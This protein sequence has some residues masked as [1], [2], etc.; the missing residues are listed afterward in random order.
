MDLIRLTDEDIIEE[1]HKSIYELIADAIHEATRNNIKADSIVINR[2]L[3]RVPERYGEYPTMIC[4]LKAY[5]TSCDLPDDYLFA[6]LQD[7]SPMTNADRIRAM[8]DEEL[9]HF[10]AWHWNKKDYGLEWLKRTK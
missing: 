2:N 3:V 10:L 6:V 1:A 9:A 5:N 4:G 8:T 7:N